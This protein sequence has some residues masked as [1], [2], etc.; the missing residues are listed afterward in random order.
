MCAEY[1]DELGSDLLCSWH[2]KQLV[3]EI[4]SFQQHLKASKS[5]ISLVSR[6]VI[7]QLPHL[8]DSSRSLKCG[9]TDLFNDMLVFR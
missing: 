6:S 3:G 7:E 5:E 8:Q 1:T 4:G 2:L 9:D